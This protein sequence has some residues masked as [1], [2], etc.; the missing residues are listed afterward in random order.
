MSQFFASGG[1]SIGAS[2][3]PSVRPINIQDWF[4]LELT[5]LISLQFK[6]LSFKSILQ[7]H[8]SKASIHWDSVYLQSNS[9]MHIWLLEKQ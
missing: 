9:H 4:S 1:Q 5:G 3:S 6:E 2:V 7:H 8:S